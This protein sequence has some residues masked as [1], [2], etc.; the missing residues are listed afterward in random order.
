LPS[1]IENSQLPEKGFPLQ[2]ERVRV[3]GLI[4]YCRQ[5]SWVQKRL[6]AILMPASPEISYRGM[7][8]TLSVCG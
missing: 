8:D 4:F 2:R 6:D 5:F 1:F 3:R 7:L